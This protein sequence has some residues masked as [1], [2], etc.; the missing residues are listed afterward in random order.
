LKRFL[1]ARLELRPRLGIG[2]EHL[3]STMASNAP[4]SFIC[5]KPLA[6]M[7]ASTLA[8]LRPMPQRVEHLLGRAIADGV[9]SNSRQ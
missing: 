7:M 1:V 5:L 9:V 8:A 2:G 4:L 3:S 6:S